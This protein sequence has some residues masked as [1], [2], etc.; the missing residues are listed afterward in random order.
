MLLGSSLDG[1]GLNEGC[2][3]LTRLNCVKCNRDKAARV[4]ETQRIAHFLGGHW[5]S[6]AAQ[7]CKN[8][9]VMGGAKVVRAAPGIA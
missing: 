8:C 9:L 5:P 1:A 4:K 3:A 7:D 6:G 2:N